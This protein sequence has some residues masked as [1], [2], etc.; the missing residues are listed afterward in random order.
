MRRPTNHPDAEMFQAWSLDGT[1]IAFTSDRDGND[2]IYV[3][4]IY[5]GNVRQLTI[6]PSTGSWPLWSATGT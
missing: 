5:S 3:L 6:H 4:D 2:D 1:Q